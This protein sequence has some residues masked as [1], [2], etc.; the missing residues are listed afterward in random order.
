MARVRK[1]QKNGKELP[2]LDALLKSQA[3]EEQILSDMVTF[4]GG[5]HT[6]AYYI[7]WTF[8]YLAQNPE[9]QEKLFRDVKEKVGSEHVEKL[10][11]YTLTSN[12][13][14]R[15][16]LDEVLR[17]STTVPFSAHY[18]DQDTVVDGY[19]VPAKTPIIHAIGVTMKNKTIWEK[20][21]LFN[22]DRFTPGSI[23]AK[24]GLEF[25]PFGVTH[26]RRCPANQF[27]YFMASV[28]VT[29]LVQRFVFL[30]VDEQMPEKKYGIA[31]SPKEDIYIQVRFRD[32]E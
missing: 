31:T 5:F 14:M 27:T 23:C 7:T 17:M 3:P 21:D 20:P 2:L 4:M 15:Q 8:F 11:A 25:R 1:E 10:R 9:V 26:I 24:R 18:C 30:T 6:S 13:F 29:I 28:F 32:Q 12:S 19:H 22:P 16:V